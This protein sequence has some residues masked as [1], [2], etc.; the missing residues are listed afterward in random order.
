MSKYKVSFISSITENCICFPIKPSPELFFLFDSLREENSSNYSKLVLI[1]QYTKC[2][3][4]AKT[5]SPQTMSRM[6]TTTPAG[7]DQT[8]SKCQQ[9]HKPF[10]DNTK[11]LATHK[12]LS[13]SFKTMLKLSSTT[14]TGS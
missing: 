8:I 10:S 12:T 13:G 1:R 2:Q 14:Q 4:H 7:P 9:K 6:S 3:Q 5:G 11:K